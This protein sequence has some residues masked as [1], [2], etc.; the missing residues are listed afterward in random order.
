[1]IDFFLFACE[2]LDSLLSVFCLIFLGF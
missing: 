2:I 1:M